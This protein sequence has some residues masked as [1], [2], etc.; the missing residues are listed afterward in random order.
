M[1]LY[2]IMYANACEELTHWKRPDAGKDLRR[3]E[4]G[5]TEDGM[6]GWHPRLDVRE[7]G[8]T[9][10]A[11]DGRGGLVLQSQT[12]LSDWTDANAVHHLKKKCPQRTVSLDLVIYN[13]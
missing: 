10:G 3:E 6:V 12:E 13:E 9:L 1:C 5:T 8:W 11:G 7:S 2:T 4:K